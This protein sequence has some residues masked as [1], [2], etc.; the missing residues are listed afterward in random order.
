M[1]IRKCVRCGE[2]FVFSDSNLYNRV[3]DELDTNG[4]ENTSLE[5]MDF[6][7]GELCEECFR[8]VGDI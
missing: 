1:E 3:V 4:E 2:Y 6:L 5:R 7:A 8:E